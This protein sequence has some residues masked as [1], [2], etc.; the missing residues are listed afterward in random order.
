MRQGISDSDI[1]RTMNGFNQ[2]QSRTTKTQA[3]PGG[4]DMISHI[5]FHS[6]PAFAGETGE[7]EVLSG[8]EVFGAQN[9]AC[10]GPHGANGRCVGSGS[11]VD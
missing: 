9:A 2:K 4:D 3:L 5:S 1:S 11:T 7:V 8:G 10:Q 6:D